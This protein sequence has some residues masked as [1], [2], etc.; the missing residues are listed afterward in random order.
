MSSP[1]DPTSVAAAKPRRPRY[2]ATVKRVQNL[3]PRMV[4][5]TFT[6]PELAAIGHGHG[7]REAA[8]R[9]HVTER[10]GGGDAFD[11]R[12]E[13]G[14]VRQGE[15]AQHGGTG[16]ERFARTGGRGHFEG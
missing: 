16:A 2:P 4:R 10:R 15:A 3:T 1:V 14:C 8:G 9:R 5:V 6:S 11:G 12:G 7:H 13:L